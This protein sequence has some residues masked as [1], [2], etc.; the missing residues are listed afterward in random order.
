MTRN[1][2]VANILVRLSKPPFIEDLV[3]HVIEGSYLEVQSLNSTPYARLELAKVLVAGSLQELDGALRSVMGMEVEEIE[4]YMPETYRRI[5]GFLR[6]LHDLE[7]LPA[8]LERGGTASGVFQEC[9]G[10]A[11][12][13]VLRAYFNRLAG[14]MEATGEQPGLP[15]SMVALVLYGMYLRYKLGLGKIGLERVEELETGFEDVPRSLGGEGSIYYYNSVVKLE[16]KS[17]T[18]ADNPFT[19]IA[20]EARI[21]TEASKTAL[22]YRGGLL[23]ILTHFF[24]VRFYEAKLLRIIVSRRILNVG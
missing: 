9:V 17:G 19:Y 10:K 15:L 5:A 18:W 3:K 1:D 13:C 11:L 2:A 22:Y 21:V 7:G 24:I 8:E 16:E 23:N 4:E 20:E 12:P 14:L 6:L